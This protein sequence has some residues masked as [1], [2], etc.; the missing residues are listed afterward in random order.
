MLLFCFLCLSV[1]EKVSLKFKITEEKRAFSLIMY[2]TAKVKTVYRIIQSKLQVNLMDFRIP[3]FENYKANQRLHDLP[4]NYNE[5]FEIILNPLTHSSGAPVHITERPNI[6][7]P[8]I[9]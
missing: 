6:S 9:Y 5:R 7:S 2:D 4:F 1:Q 8:F 3:A